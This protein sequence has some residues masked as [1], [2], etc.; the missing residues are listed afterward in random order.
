MSS[1]LDT[2]RF[3]KALL[4]ERVRVR[5]AIDYL[6]QEN[7]GSIED[8]TQEMPI[9]NH[10]GEMA[11]VTFD[12][13]LDYTLEEN[14]ERLLAAIDAALVRIDDGTF[15]VCKSCAEPINEE[16]LEALPHTTQCIECKRREE[17]G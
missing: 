9:D 7:P 12:R 16:R 15:G 1:T 3:R 5:G 11:S 2:E 10:L 6:H 8:E 4:E 14:E 17:R 13:E